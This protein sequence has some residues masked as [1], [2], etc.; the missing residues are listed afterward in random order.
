LYKVS[1]IGNKV[2]KMRAVWIHKKQRSRQQ[3]LRM[4][5]SPLWPPTTKFLPKRILVVSVDDCLEH[6]RVAPPFLTGWEVADA[7]PI[8]QSSLQQIN[9]NVE[10]SDLFCAPS[11]AST[12]SAQERRRQP[13]QGDEALY[14]DLNSS[15]FTPIAKSIKK[16]ADAQREMLVDRAEIGFARCSWRNNTINQTEFSVVAKAFSVAVLSSWTKHISIASSMLD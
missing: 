9:N 12:S 10:A 5:M 3:R 2:D 14:N 13:G 1:L 11:T 7:H 6:Y 16:L 8:L 15:L 4:E